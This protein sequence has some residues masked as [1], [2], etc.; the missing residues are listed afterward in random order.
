MN[1]TIEIGFTDDVF[2]SFEEVRASGL[3][4][5]WDR[6]CVQEAAEGLVDPE[7]AL[8]AICDDGK[9]Y[10]RLLMAFGACKRRQQRWMD[11]EVDDERE[12]DGQ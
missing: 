7:C 1:E 10:S 4:N 8:F 9:T 6:R 2:E 11:D 3:C 12:R 5:M